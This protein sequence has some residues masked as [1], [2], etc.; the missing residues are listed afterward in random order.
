M[1]ETTFKETYKWLTENGWKKINIGEYLIEKK[2]KKHQT[3][4]IG[5]NGFF[6]LIKSNKQIKKLEEEN[7]A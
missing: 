6:K 1:T 2:L 7:E 4:R 5:T 3:S